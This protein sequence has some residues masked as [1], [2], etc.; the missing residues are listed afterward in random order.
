VSQSAWKYWFRFGCKV[1]V[2][3]N[4]ENYTVSAV[5]QR[6]W[7]GFVQIDNFTHIM[8]QLYGYTQS[9]FCLSVLT[10]HTFKV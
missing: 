3:K 6:T 9:R 1:C 2:E 4:N 5:V 10:F 7:N 8:T